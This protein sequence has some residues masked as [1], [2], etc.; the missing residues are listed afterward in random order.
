[1]KRKTEETAQTK[2]PNFWTA[3]HKK[4]IFEYSVIDLIVLGI[5]LACFAAY[6]LA[7][8]AYSVTTARYNTGT[9]AQ[10]EEVVLA[11]G[12]DNTEEDFRIYFQ[13]YNVVHELGHGLIHYN[14]DTKFGKAEEEQLVNDFAIAYWM[15]YGEADKLERMEH[16]T[17]TAM[18]NLHSDAEPGQTY[19]D[20]ANARWGKKGFFTFRNY[21]WFQFSSSHTS[22]QNK[23]SMDAVLK[24]MGIEGYSLPSDPQKLTYGTI[25]EAVSDQ[26]LNDAVQNINSWG[27]YF[28]KVYHKYHDDP[29]DN[30]SRPVKDLGFIAF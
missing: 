23:K 27:L 11:L 22:L 21:G 8:K 28:P 26:I 13:W 5:M 10:N 9:Q 16:I 1:M 3:R 18:N 24:S 19:M 12:S 17:S 7:P 30:Y 29:N 15:M 4:G 6:F 25:S 20:F 14:S 2:K